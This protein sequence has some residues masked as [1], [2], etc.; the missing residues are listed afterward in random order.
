MTGALSDVAQRHAA[1]DIWS[2]EGQLRRTQVSI[3]HPAR[4][5]IVIK[6][7]GLFR[8]TA[9]SWNA[10]SPCKGCFVSQQRRT[11]RNTKRQ[12]WRNK[13]PENNTVILENKLTSFVVLFLRVFK[14]SP[15]LVIHFP[16][17]AVI[18]L[19]HFSS[20]TLFANCSEI[21][22]INESL[23]SVLFYTTRTPKGPP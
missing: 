5:T 16:D 1:G 11:T 23:L 15:G 3:V 18:F 21:Q 14:T 17:R 2:N 22:N 19:A 4:L 20:R 8:V 12:M 9:W 7:T 6:G 13:V 10:W